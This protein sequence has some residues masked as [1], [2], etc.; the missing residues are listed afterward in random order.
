MSRKM[1]FGFCLVALGIAA[2]GRPTLGHGPF[3][4]AS[5]RLVPTF[6][7]DPLWPKL[8]N[9]WILGEVTAVAVGPRDHVWVLHR[10]RTVAPDQTVNAAPAVLEFDESGT[11]VRGWGGPAE[12]YEWPDTEHN[13]SVDG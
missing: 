7:A 12:G 9:H 5:D 8:P 6:E 3:A 13:I 1:G 10:P 4:P 11:F 2:A